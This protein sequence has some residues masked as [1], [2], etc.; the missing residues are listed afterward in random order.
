MVASARDASAWMQ[1]EEP[2][3]VAVAA[4]EQAAEGHGTAVEPVVVQAMGDREMVVGWADDGR[5]IATCRGRHRQHGSAL[6]SQVSSVGLPV[7]LSWSW[8]WS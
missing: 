2:V 7:A 3:V 1:N 8:S 4:A 5:N 6:D